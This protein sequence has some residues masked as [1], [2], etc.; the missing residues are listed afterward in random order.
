MQMVNNLCIGFGWLTI[1]LK[2]VKADR[3]WD[4]KPC[5]FIVR[6]PCD[7]YV[8]FIIDGD[9]EFQTPTKH[10]TRTTDDVYDYYTTKRISKKALIKIEVWDEDW[11]A[12]DL[13]MMTEGHVDSFLR[14]GYRPGRNSGSYIDTVSFWQD[15]YKKP[16]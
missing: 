15:E 6:D 12:D 14:S 16:V 4:D 7:P 3:T 5:E 8:K 10:D 1:K 9:L 13:I 11:D 2:S